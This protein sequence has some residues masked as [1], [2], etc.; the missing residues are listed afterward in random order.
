MRTKTNRKNEIRTKATS[1]RTFE[2]NMT[3]SDNTPTA[4]KRWLNLHK[5][6][7]VCDSLRA[8]YNILLSYHACSVLNSNARTSIYQILYKIFENIKLFEEKTQRFK[9]SQLTWRCCCF[10]CLLSPSTLSF[11]L[12][13]FLDLQKNCSKCVPCCEKKEKEHKE[14]L[15]KNHVI[16][17]CQ[18]WKWFKQLRNG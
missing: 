13:I 2:F 16:H 18:R 4:A 9:Y 1:M 3:K 7:T 6:A 12:N 15:A 10:W 11:F 8:I 14:E 17:K 5:F